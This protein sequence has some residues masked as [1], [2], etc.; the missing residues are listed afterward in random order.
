MNLGH[1]D[2]LCLWQTVFRA[3][4]FIS[5]RWAL[6][7]YVLSVREP[8]CQCP[9]LRPG[10]NDSLYFLSVFNLIKLSELV[11]TQ[12]SSSPALLFYKRRKLG[13]RGELNLLKITQLINGRGQS[14]RQAS[15]LLSW[16]SLCRSTVSLPGQSP[17][18]FTS[19]QHLFFMPSFILFCLLRS[20]FTF[21]RCSY[22]MVKI[23]LN[24]R[25]KDRC[26][27]SVVFALDLVNLN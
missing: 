9:T 17:P 13:S 10:V 26:E 1:T 2:V 3:F 22:L 8:L 27:L 25:W 6:R 5:L 15:C 11:G 12:R 20:L 24:A 14:R 18:S 23:S 4:C 7:W 21:L 19:W 16:C